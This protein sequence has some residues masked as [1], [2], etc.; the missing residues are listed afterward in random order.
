MNAGDRPALVR[1][2][3]LRVDRISGRTMILAPERGFVLNASA[4]SIVALC[5]GRRT[6]AEIADQLAIACRAP[7]AIVERDV[8]TL[9]DQLVRK[10]LVRA[11]ARS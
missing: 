11:E 10:R 8:L 6:A 5:D 1:G 2:A 3:R 9:L 4:Q 7:R